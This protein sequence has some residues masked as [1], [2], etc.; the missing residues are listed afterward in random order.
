[1]CD[2]QIGIFLLGEFKNEVG[3]AGIIDLEQ[4]GP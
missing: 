4:Y 2:P 1:M 3:L